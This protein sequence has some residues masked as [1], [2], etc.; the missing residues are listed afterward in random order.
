[1]KEEKRAEGEIANS[2]AEEELEDLGDIFNNINDLED[3]SQ[4]Y[5]SG[6]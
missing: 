6:T 5:K 2:Y 1:L 4:K 3:F